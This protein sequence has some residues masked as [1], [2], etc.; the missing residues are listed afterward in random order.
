MITPSVN[1][2]DAQ[3]LL[4]LFCK[5]QNLYIG[6]EIY[7]DHIVAANTHIAT[8]PVK[9]DIRET[10]KTEENSFKGKLAVKWRER[11]FFSHGDQQCECNNS[12]YFEYPASIS[13]LEM[14]L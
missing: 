7:F 2:W 10:H 3:D 13:H 4:I 1:F 9:A 5:G 11:M 8:Y 14:V 6:G 12:K